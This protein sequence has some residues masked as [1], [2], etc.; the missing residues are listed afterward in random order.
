MTLLLAPRQ[1]IQDEQFPALFGLNNA[2]YA[3][4]K[5]ICTHAQRE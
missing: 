3:N 1:T 2:D 5:L 4:W